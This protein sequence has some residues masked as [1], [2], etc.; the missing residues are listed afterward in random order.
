MLQIAN[1]LLSKHRIDKA[2]QLNIRRVL[3]ADL[4]IKS[5]KLFQYVTNFPWKQTAPAT[6]STSIQRF[7][8]REALE[9]CLN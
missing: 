3:T 9:F 1:K 5:I 2:I 4:F 8:M 6:R 7:L